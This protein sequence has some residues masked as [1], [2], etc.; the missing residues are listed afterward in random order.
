MRDLRCV[1]QLHHSSQCQILNPLSGAR[2]R[3]RIF[4]DTEPRGEL[5]DQAFLRERTAFAQPVQGKTNAVT[6]VLVPLFSLP[7][8]LFLKK[9]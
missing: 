2:D 6:R 5:Q 9:N 8:T 1:L 3:T 4:R 7:F